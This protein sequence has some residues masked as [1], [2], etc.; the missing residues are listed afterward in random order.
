MSHIS[1]LREL[2]CHPIPRRTGQGGLPHRRI[3]QLSKPV[4][5]LQL[6]GMERGDKHKGGEPFQRGSSAAWSATYRLRARRAIATK[7]HRRPLLLRQLVAALDC[8]RDVLVATMS[9]CCSRDGSPPR[10]T[11]RE[12]LP[13]GLEE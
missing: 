7:G 4:L 9:S 11:R 3:E 12:L 1:L 5:F 6:G 13:V 8:I 10:G 2:G